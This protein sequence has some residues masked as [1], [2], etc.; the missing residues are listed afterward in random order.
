[1]LNLFPSM[2][3]LDTRKLGYPGPTT[4]EDNTT[5]DHP[6]IRVEPYIPVERRWWES[7]LR[8]NLRPLAAVTSACP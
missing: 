8:R 5:M 1:M 6:R 4:L 7:H 2:L 3:P